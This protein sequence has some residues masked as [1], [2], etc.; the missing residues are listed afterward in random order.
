MTLPGFSIMLMFSF[1]SISL[2][3]SRTISLCIMLSI[4]SSELNLPLKINT[5]W[6]GDNWNVDGFEYL[7]ESGWLELEI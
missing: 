5:I 2:S 6:F 1:S 4:N 7:E 3:L